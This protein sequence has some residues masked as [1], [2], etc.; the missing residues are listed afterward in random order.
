MELQFA[1][2][3]LNC[4]RT[5]VCEVQEQE[6]TQ[7]VRLPDGMPDIGRVLGAWGQC[8]LRGKQWNSGGI[9]AN[10]GVM[11]WVLYAPEDGS[12][13]R[14]VEVWMPMQM[15]WNF[16]EDS[17]REGAIRTCWRLRGVDARTLSARKLMV[18]ACACVLGEAMEPWE[19]DVST[20]DPMPEDVQL[21][22]RTYPAML[23]REAGEKAYFVEEALNLPEGCEKLLYCQAQPRVTE[24]SVVGGKAVFRG[25]LGIHLLCQCGDGQL[26]T[27]DHT[28]GFSQFSDLDRDYNSD[29][30]LDVM[31]AVSALE[32]ELQEGVLR[33][34]CGLV[35]QFL[36]HERRMLELV[37]D[38]YSPNRGVVPHK[39]R[40]ELPM[41]LDNSREAVELDAP[42]DGGKVLD[43]VF[44]PDHPQVRRAGG[45]AEVELPGVFKVIYH[46][47]QGILQGD[48]I[49]GS[50]Q[51]ELP[52][53]ENVSI[54]ACSEAE[55]WPQWSAG[56]LRGQMDVR[57]ITTADEGLPTVTGLELGEAARPDPKRPSMIL[58]R[59]GEKSLW[60]L[61]KASGSTVE[62]IRAA[63]GLM[64]EP[65]QGRMLL[66]PVT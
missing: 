23:P 18:R 20:P 9:G 27:A 15:K 53:G 14:T 60:E 7:E 28:V 64:D 46:D 17:R 47:G 35:A 19:T 65:E 42:F 31:M 1:K 41:I 22:R 38:A 26:R 62:A 43:V 50:S 10:G 8:V 29:A 25:E 5:N 32:P 34:K 11:A 57:A 61:A 6:Q 44:Y 56:A 12:E 33:L 54:R 58:C 30:E 55:G 4:L 59:A 48:T 40:L 39:E 49:R 51:W 36:V 24:Q 45:L 16:R 37:E 52:V 21:L 63:N 2:S 3:P 13:P 66:I